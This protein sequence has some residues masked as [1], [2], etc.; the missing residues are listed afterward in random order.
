MTSQTTNPNS[1]EYSPEQR[2]ARAE[3]TDDQLAAQ[4]EL[5]DAWNDTL[6]GGI[7]TA[8][9]GNDDTIAIEDLGQRVEQ[10]QVSYGI[11][12]DR[13]L[14]EPEKQLEI[15]EAGLEI[16]TRI[17]QQGAIAE[18]A[19]LGM[20]GAEYTVTHR[21][22]MNETV[23]EVV[24]EGQGEDFGR[25]SNEDLRDA[26][27]VTVATKFDKALRQGDAEAIER[28]PVSV[29]VRVK[30]WL[31]DIG[32]RYGGAE[33]A[34]NDQLTQ[35]GEYITFAEKV[36]DGSNKETVAHVDAGGEVI[37]ESIDDIVMRVLEGDP[38][39]IALLESDTY[40]SIKDQYADFMAQ[41]GNMFAMK[42]EPED[43]D[44]LIKRIKRSLL[45][46]NA[47]RFASAT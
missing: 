11:D 25:L 23:A 6:Y 46:A 21:D 8:K 31:G 3:L 12:G 4:D 38:E 42:L 18:L 33:F 14:S 47:E 2:Q 34:P 16:D 43:Q 45:S 22:A 7:G 28:L 41:Y 35:I 32:Q 13:Y 5:H 19:A 30:A 36:A 15:D 29:A 26:R 1:S 9:L 37:V 39:A 20:D 10:Q 40:E 27:N 17:V 44:L 24:A